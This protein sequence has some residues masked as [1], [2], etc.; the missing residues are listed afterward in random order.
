[1]V[2]AVVGIVA[3]ILHSAFLTAGTPQF[4]T[5]TSIALLGVWPVGSIT[6]L[7]V[8]I[9]EADDSLPNRPLQPMTAPES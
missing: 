7:T 8:A 2:L 6:Q 4:R 5:E 3:A 1:V 9:R